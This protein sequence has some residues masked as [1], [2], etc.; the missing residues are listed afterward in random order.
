V[1]L[2][3]FKKKRNFEKNYFEKVRAW[4]W[5]WHMGVARGEKK[6]IDFFQ[7]KKIEHFYIF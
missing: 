3:A 7:K 2:Q 5:V 4:P 6:N 1:C